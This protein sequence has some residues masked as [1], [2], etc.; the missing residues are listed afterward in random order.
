MNPQLIILSKPTYIS[1]TGVASAAATYS[2]ITRGYKPPVQGRALQFDTVINQNGRF[3]WVYDNGPGFR[4]WSPFEIV[5][6]DNF[7]GILGDN[8]RIQYQH[9]IALW[10]YPGTLGID[11]PEGVFTV[12]WT[13]TDLQL[14]H[15]AY[16]KA[17]GATIDYVVTVEF[18]EGS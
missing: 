8:A 12:H 4:K 1:P 9:I 18:E 6:D 17:T 16:P 10:E 2:F 13:N 11:T 14:S 7:Q 5:C 15:R 3:K